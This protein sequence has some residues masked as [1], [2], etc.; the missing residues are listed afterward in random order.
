M[1]AF[2]VQLFM[3]THIRMYVYVYTIEIVQL[4]CTTEE[5]T[6]MIT[7]VAEIKLCYVT[8]V[9]VAVTIKVLY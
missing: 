4:L 9:T 5:C 7:Y 2:H 1:H 3:Y 8:V 6:L